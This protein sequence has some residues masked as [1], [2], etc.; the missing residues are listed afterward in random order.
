LTGRIRT[1]TISAVY[2]LQ[3]SEAFDD[4]IRTLRDQ[5]ARARILARLESAERGNL[6]DVKAVGAGIRE[7]RIHHGPGYRVYFA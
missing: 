4:W 3:S 2:Q 7:M 5:T 1:D 6:G